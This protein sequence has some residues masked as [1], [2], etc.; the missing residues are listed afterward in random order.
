MGRADLGE[1]SFFIP[2]SYTIYNIRVLVLKLS[3]FW[4]WF[5]GLLVDGATF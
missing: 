1:A 4:F 3:C 2:T 5:L